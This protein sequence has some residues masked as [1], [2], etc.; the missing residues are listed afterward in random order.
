MLTYGSDGNTQH[1]W[2]FLSFKST[3]LFHWEPIKR[4]SNDMTKWYKLQYLLDIKVNI[5]D[6][7]FDLYLRKEYSMD[8]SGYA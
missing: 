2:V 4:E 6:A 5:Y 7:A 3:C 1:I 8:L